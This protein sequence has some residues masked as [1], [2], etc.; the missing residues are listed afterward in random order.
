[1]SVEAPQLA[2]TVH[3]VSLGSKGGRFPSTCR[4]SIVT[5]VDADH[6]PMHVGLMVANPTGLFFHSLAEGGAFHDT[7]NGAGTWHWHTECQQ[8]APDGT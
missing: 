3:Y 4:A 6:D 8:S 5:E 2:R 1:M 7:A